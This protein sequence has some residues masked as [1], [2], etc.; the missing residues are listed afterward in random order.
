MSALAHP[1]LLR[2][3]VDGEA[4]A[5]AR[6]RLLQRPE[7][8]KILIVISD[9]AP[10]DDATL[11]HNGP[12][13]LYRHLMRVLA[14]V[15]SELIVGA[16]GVNHP[17]EAWYAVSETAASAEELPDAAAKLLDRL[18]ERARQPLATTS[19]PLGIVAPTEG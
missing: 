15:Q 10:V 4:I 2:E 6:D 13:Y 9:G 1:G 3:N 8:R 11:F 17:V 19:G 18:L 5:W 14:G 7:I 12:S 16:I